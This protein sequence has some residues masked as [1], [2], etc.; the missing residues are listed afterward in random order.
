MAKNLYKC[1]ACNI[2]KTKAKK[3]KWLEAHESY[4]ID[5]KK[6]TCQ[7]VE[8]VSLCH[9]CHNYIHQGRLRA[10]VEYGRE[11]KE[12]LND[13]LRHGD[14]LTAHLKRPPVPSPVDM[15]PWSE[16]VL[17]IDGTPYPS[18]FKTQQEWE[19][20]YHWINTTGYPDNGRSLDRFRE[21]I[22][23]ITPQPTRN[24]EQHERPG[25]TL[26]PSSTCTRKK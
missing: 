4:N 18:R 22:A 5:W 3:H 1:W 19:T 26:S 6:G 20:Y 11:S 24:I 9:Y 16:W 21:T 2:P 25:P 14:N 12:F 17:L 15:A 7:L 23:D 13:V 8:I 10:L